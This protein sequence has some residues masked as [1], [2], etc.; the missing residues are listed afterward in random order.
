MNIG[1]KHYNIHNVDTF[2]P[3]KIWTYKIKKN[4]CTKYLEKYDA[5]M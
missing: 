2:P 4:E 1:L 3:F 5:K